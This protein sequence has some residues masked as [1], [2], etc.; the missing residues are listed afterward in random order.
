MSCSPNWCALWKC[1]M[2]Y[3]LNQVETWFLKVV[4]N[5]IFV[6]FI[7]GSFAELVS[8]TITLTNE[9]DDHMCYRIYSPHEYYEFEP[10]F[11]VV[12]PKSKTVVKGMLCDSLFLFEF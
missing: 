11:G 10:V 4:L 1:P 6:Y 3:Q 8:S 12:P 7:L 5:G 2:K 9:Y